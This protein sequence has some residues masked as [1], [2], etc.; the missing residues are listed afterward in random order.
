MREILRVSA[1]SHKLKNG[2][3][4]SLSSHSK[5]E[6]GKCQGGRDPLNF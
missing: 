4:K 5:I 6:E 3:V 2:N 1:V